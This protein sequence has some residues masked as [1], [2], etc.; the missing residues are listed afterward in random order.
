MLSAEQ[1]ND[2]EQVEKWGKKKSNPKAK[3]RLYLGLFPEMK[4]AN[5]N[6]N[7]FPI[8]ILE[9][10]AAKEVNMDK[11]KYVTENTCAFDS[12]IQVAQTSY[13][14]SEKF[15]EIIDASSLPI[16]NFIES[17]IKKGINAKTY[18][19][20]A[21]LLS[22]NL[23]TVELQNGVNLIKSNRSIT[24]IA[25]IFFEQEPSWKS[26]AECQECG[27][28]IP[29]TEVIVEF[30]I[31]RKQIDHLENLVEDFLTGE[32]ICSCEEGKLQK[33]ETSPTHFM[34]RL[35]EDGNEE[36]IE[37][38]LLLGDIPKSLKTINQKYFLRGVIGYRAK[39]FLHYEGKGY[40][41]AF[42]YRSVNCWE[43]YDNRKR[44]KK[45]CK[46]ST[47][48]RASLIYYSV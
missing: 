16:A 10:G 14:D 7:V 39:D 21:R 19:E 36:D 3:R 2:E 38:A 47:K 43:E 1:E 48:V 20:R 33:S 29:R 24:A 37:M 18:E 4:E 41:T 12:I 22:K 35:I 23:T 31:C 26:L 46:E 8:G 42:C 9:N 30:V 25:Q 15:K 13:V 34:V 44:K 27:V 5:F 11:K 6:R 32:I 40:Y 28:N 17:V 45:G